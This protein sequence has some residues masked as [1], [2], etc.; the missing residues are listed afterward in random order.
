MRPPTL[1][2]GQA[3]R[4]DRAADRTQRRAVPAELHLDRGGRAAL[5][6]AGG[7]D[8]VGQRGPLVAGGGD[9]DLAA[10]G[11]RVVADEALAGEE[12]RAPR[13]KRIAVAVAHEHA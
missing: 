3:A 7:V 11:A 10:R 9:A 6:R 1:P 5:L 13:P 8:A 4:R 12:E 2:S